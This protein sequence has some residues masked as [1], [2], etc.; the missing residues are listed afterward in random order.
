[1]PSVAIVGAGLGGIAT[2]VKLCQAGITDFTIFEQSAG[3]G[4]TWWDNTYPG[5]A[6]DVDIL[7]YQF[8]FKL[9]DWKRTHASQAEMQQYVQD[10][11]EEFGLG[12]HLR[13][14]TR[15]DSA[16]WDERQHFYTLTTAA[17][18][19]PRFD[20]VVSALGLH[21]VPRYPDWPGL[22]TFTG[23]KFHTARW[24][25]EHDLHGK[26][27]AVVGAGSSAAQVVPAL[28]PIAETVTMF[29]REATHVIP[30]IERPYTPEE[31]RDLATPSGKRR[32]RAK[33]FRELER[34]SAVRNP[35][36]KRQREAQMALG[37][38]RQKMLGDRPDLLAI[39]TPNHP[40]QCKRPVFSADLFPVLKRPNVRVVPRE[41]VRVT[42]TG[43]VDAH[44]VEHPA[45]VLVMATGF[46]PWAFS[47]TLEVVGR[48]GRTLRGVWGQEPQAFLGV[49]VA[50]F[51]NF[52]MLYGPN[53]NYYCVTLLLER[54]AEFIAA[55]VKRLGR[56]HSTAIE[57]RGWVMDLYNVLVRRT[58]AG[59]VAD[60]GCHNYYHS[61]S[62]RNVVTWPWTGTSYMFLSKLGWFTSFTRR[63]DPAKRPRKIPL[64]R[65]VT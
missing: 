46:Q 34:M 35:K 51:P 13:F 22:E 54:Q 59:Q 32:A 41:V 33:L 24:E 18:E 28:A 23:P 19:S 40:V 4:G 57:V 48:F 29:V 38:F 20:V 10:I 61:A 31:A 30:K 8:S 2:G 5:A 65:A 11:I 9:H 63:A 47:K 60:A 16:V 50:G 26:Q 64:E 6:C 43:V 25:H 36:S 3:P 49:Q 52:F 53:S 1:M 37:G 7:L 55:A 14:N 42:E 58:L 27:V 12:P 45:D 15:V 17:G 44:G 39:F 21:N 56:T 62:G